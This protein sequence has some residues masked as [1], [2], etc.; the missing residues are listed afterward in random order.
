V[1]QHIVRQS[2]ESADLRGKEKWA[3]TLSAA[4]AQLSRTKEGTASLR[5]VNAELYQ[6]DATEWRNTVKRK[7]KAESLLKEMETPS[8]SAAQSKGQSSEKAKSAAKE[9]NAK[10]SVAPA[11]ASKPAVAAKRALDGADGEDSGE[12]GAD[13]DAQQGGEKTARKRK[14]KRPNKA[15][16]AVPL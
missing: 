13:G 3:L 12:E 14:R 9:S 5:L 8:A 6:R 7:L 16:G 4:S 11:A 1:G 15:G 2:F 10:Q